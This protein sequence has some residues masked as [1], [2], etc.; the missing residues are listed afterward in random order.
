[1]DLNLVAVVMIL[2]AIGLLMVF[3]ASFVRAQQSLG[4]PYYYLK[5]QALWAVVGLAV[6]GLASQVQYW[7]WR[8]LARPLMYAPLAAPVLGVLPGGGQPEG[9][10]LYK[11]PSPRD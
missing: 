7:H 9:R 11:S 2:L 1:M 8:A 4:D 5:R 10:L 6:M 3:S